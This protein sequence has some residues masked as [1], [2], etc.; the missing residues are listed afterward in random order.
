MGKLLFDLRI[1]YAREKPTSRKMV[2]HALIIGS[3]PVFAVL[4]AVYPF[5]LLKRERAELVLE[6]T[7][8]RIEKPKFQPYTE[9]QK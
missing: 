9:R 4:V 8:S 2:Y 3:P 7:G 5:L 1:Y 6:Y